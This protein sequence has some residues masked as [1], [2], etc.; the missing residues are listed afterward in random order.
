MA[1][2]TE[3]ISITNQA[4][5]MTAISIMENV[6]P[7]ADGVVDEQWLLQMRESLLEKYQQLRTGNMA[8]IGH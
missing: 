5:I 6:V 2:G 7:D 3:Y 4:K 8:T 1:T